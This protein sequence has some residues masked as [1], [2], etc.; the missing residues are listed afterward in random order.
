[1]KAEKKLRNAIPSIKS[2]SHSVEGFVLYFSVSSLSLGL[3]PGL[4]VTQL[5]RRHC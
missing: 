4:S 2:V 1:M 5:I 3:L